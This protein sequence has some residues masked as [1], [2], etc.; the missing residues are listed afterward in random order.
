MPTRL[1]PIPGG[2]GSASNPWEAAPQTRVRGR[3]RA[4]PGVEARP[5]RSTANGPASN[6][7]AENAGAAA[8]AANAQPQRPRPAASTASTAASAAQAKLL[9][10]YHQATSTSSDDVATIA[11]AARPAAVEPA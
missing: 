7:T 8:D 3:T 4:T 1:R 11:T 6:P 10:E 9:A 2:T 5:P